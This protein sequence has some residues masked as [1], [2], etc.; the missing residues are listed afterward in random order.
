MKLA[1][2]IALRFLSSNKGQTILIALGI[3]IGIS[4]QIFIGSLI[5]GLQISLLDATIGQASHIS[6]EGAN[7]LD[8][9][10]QHKEI[11]EQI[12]EEYEIVTAISPTI[13]RGAFL[14]FEDISEQILFR[15]FEI[16]QANKIYRFDEALIAGD[17]PAEGEV[18]IGSL[19]AE[20]KGLSQG[21]QL[22]ILTADGQ[23]TN[24]VLAGIFDLKLA[25]INNS[26]VIGDLKL[27][28][29]ITGYADNQVSAIEMQIAEPFDADQVSESIAK[30]LS[31]PNIVLSNWKTANEQ[32][33]S[34]LNGQSTSSLM[35]QVFVVISVVLGIA[36]V[37]AITVLQKSKQIGILK[38][39]GINDKSASFVFLFQGFILGVIGGLVGI[40]LGLLLLWFFSNFALNPDGTPV[41]P[42]YINLGFII[43]S[44]F[45][46]VLASTAASI[47]PAL[48][49][50]K[51]S[52]IE[53]IRH[54]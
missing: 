40:V 12:R 47:I 14:L 15:G 21:D 23:V 31:N 19:L 43:L 26:W 11:E 32:L 37:L 41:V 34:G 3:G 48:K 16:D 39:M 17:F 53:I 42:I 5:Q 6:I 4:V 44:A 38:A 22:K 36:S 46:A 50:K 29:G 13:S 20:T 8:T 9:I 49:S 52:P 33:L 51:L 2:R 24:V 54:G 18:L 30:R 25:A 35:I 7:S 27:A 1:F 10:D 45:I 28:R